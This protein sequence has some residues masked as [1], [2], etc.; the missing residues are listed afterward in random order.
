MTKEEWIDIS[1]SEE[2]VAREASIREL[3][4]LV[5]EFQ[6]AMTRKVCDGGAAEAD[7]AWDALLTFPL[8]KIKGE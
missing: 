8:D 3:V 7:K 6:R 1:P 5:E 2:T 4:R